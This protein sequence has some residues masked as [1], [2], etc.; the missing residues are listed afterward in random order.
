MKKEVIQQFLREALKKKEA[1]K[2]S[3]LRLLLA[4]IEKEEIE[5]QRELEEE[6][7]FSLIQKE[8]KQREEAIEFFKKGGRE[9]LVKKAEGEICFLKSLLPPPLTEEEIE[10]VIKGVL[11][12]GK[13]QNFGQIMGAVMKE[14]RGKVSGEI[15]A[16]K[17]KEIMAEGNDELCGD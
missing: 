8:I 14:L 3:V 7:I 9:D 6:E 15:A 11:E 12:E 17:V 13:D 10:K 5:K 16:R 1:E 2:V 4:A